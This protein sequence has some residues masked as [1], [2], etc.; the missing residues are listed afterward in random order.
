MAAFS[1][2]PRIRGNVRTAARRI[3]N[4][5]EIQSVRREGL[6]GEDLST[7]SGRASELW[8]RV[9]RGRQLINRPKKMSRLST[10]GTNGGHNP[11]SRFIFLQSAERPAEPLVES[12]CPLHAVYALACRKHLKKKQDCRRV[13]HRQKCLSLLIKVDYPLRHSIRRAQGNSCSRSVTFSL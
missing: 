5:F 3:P 13:A 8:C 11:F 2:R 6:A 7:S 10:R 4:H 12:R 1:A 9:T